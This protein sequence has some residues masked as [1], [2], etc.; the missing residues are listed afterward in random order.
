MSPVFENN[1]LTIQSIRCEEIKYFPPMYHKHA[2]LYYVVEGEMDFFVDKGRL[3]L[4][5]G[6]LCLLF[7]YILHSITK[8][9]AIVEIVLFDPFVLKGFADILQTK[10]PNNPHVLSEQ[11]PPIVPL[12][13]QK[14]RENYSSS[15]DSAKELSNAYLIATI[16]EIL[17]VIELEDV[18]YHSISTTQRILVYC[19]NHYKEDISIEQ[20]SSELHV[21]KNHISHIFTTV[22]HSNFRDYINHLRIMDAKELLTKTDKSIIEIML[23]CGYMNQSTFNRVFHK[24]CGVTPSAYRNLNKN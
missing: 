16:G 17:K 20:I 6:D 19:S 4:K 15:S 9:K 22:L 14:I 11:V 21:S 7:P 1:D 18:S 23:E 24:L 10:K 8:Q 2:E 12:L 5:K 13:I 3:T